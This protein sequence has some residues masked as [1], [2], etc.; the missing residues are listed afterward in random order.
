MDSYNTFLKRRG[1]GGERPYA[2]A[3]PIVKA[4]GI[5][6]RRVIDKDGIL[7]VDRMRPRLARRAATELS[8]QA[9]IGAHAARQA[10]AAAGLEPARLGMVIAGATALERAYPAIAIELQQALGAQDACAFDISA[11]CSCAT[12]AIAIAA[13]AIVAGSVDSALVVIPELATAQVDFRDRTSHFIFGDGAAAVVLQAADRVTAACSFRIL[14]HARHTRFSNAIRNDFGFLSRCID[15]ATEPA[16]FRQNGVKV[17]RDVVPLASG[18]ILEHLGRL[19]I[20]P[21]D[22]QRVWLHQANAHIN[23]LICEKLFGRPMDERRAP[24]ILAEH[25]NLAA[26]GA[27][28]V[29]HRFRDDLRSGSV[30]VLCSFGAGYSAGSVVVQRM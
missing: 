14:G 6:S 18:H 24:S 4:S 22:V 21:G 23:K 9:E 5:R 19:A 13:D 26:A 7:D 29:F 17:M 15:E 20:Q 8:M 11:A 1:A 27:L 10:L 3:T 30:G 25:G 12:F 2:D 16:T 28:A